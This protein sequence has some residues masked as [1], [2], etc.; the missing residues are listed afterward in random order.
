M[1][2]GDQ[3]AGMAAVFMFLMLLAQQYA[4]NNSKIAVLCSDQFAH[5]ASTMFQVERG[6][7]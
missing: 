4:I 1:A 7:I 2:D 3:R 5:L 6:S